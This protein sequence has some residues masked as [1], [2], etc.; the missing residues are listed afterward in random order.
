VLNKDGH[1]GHREWLVS[2]QVQYF[3]CLKIWKHNS[4]LACS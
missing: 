1:Q 3:S 4:L 2:I